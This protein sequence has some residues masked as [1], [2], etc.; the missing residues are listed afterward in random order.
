MAADNDLSQWADSDLVEIEQIGSTEDFVIIV[1][2]DKPGTGGRRLFINPGSSSL[3]E[4]L[5]TID[6]CDWQTLADFLIWGITNYPAQQY[7]VILWDHGTGWSLMPQLSFGSDWSSGNHLSIANGDMTKALS[8]TYN[9]THEKIDILSF[10]ACLM[11][12]I[13][14]VSAVKNYA[15]I[16]LASQTL[17]PIQGFKYDMI[18]EPL[19][20]NPGLSAEEYAREIIRA[21]IAYYTNSQAVVYSAVDVDAI[22]DLKHTTAALYNSLIN[23]APQPEL[24]NLRNSIQTIP[25]T[26][27]TP[28][29][30]DNLIDFGDFITAFKQMLQDQST[31]EWFD[32]YQHAIIESDYWGKNFSRVTGLTIWFP[33]D[34]LEFKQSYSLYKNLTWNQSL[35]PNF[36]NWF[37]NQDD[38]QPTPVSVST[39]TVGE[40]NDFELSWTN[41]CDL[42]PVFYNIIEAKKLELTFEDQCEDTTGWNITGF[43]LSSNNP[44]SGNY[45]FFSG[46]DNNLNNFIETKQPIT[47]DDYGLL[48]LYLA[49]NTEEKKDSLIIEFGRIKDVHYGSSMGWQERT[50]LLPPGTDHLKISY[51]SDGAGNKGGCYIDN[52]KLYNLE[53]GKYVRTD[54]PDTVL[55]IFNKLK[56]KYLYSVQSQ[57]LYGNQ[58]NVSNFIETE[59]NNYCLPY[60]Q[61]SPFEKDCELILDYPDSI[62]PTVA[63]YSITG[64][65]IKK[66]TAQAINQSRIHWDGKDMNNKN[67]SAGLYFVVLKANNFKKIGKIVRQR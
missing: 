53:A 60:S 8:T 44:N 7:L 34:Y 51:H 17:C 43:I 23:T 1:Q 9:Y 39:G 62:K 24:I 19:Q 32:N 20:N 65:L 25:I 63:V 14:V 45:C 27:S 31:E 21:N 26:G 54:Y 59:I 4:N 6:M 64:R 37:Y 42:A 61:P 46:N 38:E 67:I 11:Q 56:G 48:S 15:S 13:E 52:I 33:D 5:G 18:L 29:P 47:I 22:E 40:N 10:D 30:E 36:L 50:I 66:F 49:Y 28:Q 3:L 16:C 2:V 58:G 12:Q 57:D 55:Y 41:A 35:W